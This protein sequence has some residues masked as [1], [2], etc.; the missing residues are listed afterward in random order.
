MCVC[1]C[2]CVCV[3]MRPCAR[4]SVCVC[5]FVRACVRVFVRACVRVVH[6]CVGVCVMEVMRKA[7]NEVLCIPGFNVLFVLYLSV[8]PIVFMLCALGSRYTCKC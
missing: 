3:C 1:V 4:V 2:V 6:T 5:V 8:D 7:L